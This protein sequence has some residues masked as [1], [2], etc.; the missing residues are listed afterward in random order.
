MVV[1][2]AYKSMQDIVSCNVKG[3][4]FIKSKNNR[5]PKMDPWGTPQFTAD[6][7]DNLVFI[8]TR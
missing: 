8:A 2:S 4:S 1:S 5:G 7:S 3:K 6:E